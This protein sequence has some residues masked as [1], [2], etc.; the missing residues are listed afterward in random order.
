MERVMYVKQKDGTFT[1]PPAP[2][3]RIFDRLQWFRKS[4]RKYS[5]FATPMKAMAYAK[6]YQDRRKEPYRQAALT[7]E[8]Q[9]FNKRMMR[10]KAFL[11]IEKVQLKNGKLDDTVPRLISPPSTPG[12]VETGR[13]IKP[14]EKHIYK[15]IDKVFGYEVVFKGYNAEKQASILRKHWLEFN[16]PICVGCDASKFDLHV[17]HDALIYE[18]SIYEDY[19]PGDKHFKELMKCQRFITAT[20]TSQDGQVR[21]RLDRNRESGVPNTGL[22]NIT[23]ATSMF[24][25]YIRVKKVKVRVANNGDDTVIIMERKD[26]AHFMDGFHQFFLDF[27]FNMVIEEPVDVF[28]QISFC[29]TQPVFDGSIWIMVRDPR[30]AIAKDCMV[31]KPLPTEKLVKRWMCAVGKGGIS[32]TGGIP[33]WQ[34]FYQNFVNKSQG[35]KPLSDPSMESGLK[36]LSEGQTRSFKKELPPIA[37]Y[38]FWLAFGISPMSQIA[39]ENYFNAYELS[40]DKNQPL[41]CTLP[42]NL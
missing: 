12:I 2:L 4:L 11:K 32:L 17:S 38:S 23:I 30:K 36:W 8:N 7:L 37:R 26:L 15:G 34:N 39:C 1:L 21:Y 6:L 28:E 35:V 27:G 29:S 10:I 16:D 3:F 9:G 13:Y 41:F 14:I 22:G 25:E 40:A 24:A 5:Y 33:V 42:I 20:A 18:S 19:Y 31:V